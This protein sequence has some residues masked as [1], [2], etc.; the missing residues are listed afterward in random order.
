MTR[1][2]KTLKFPGTRPSFERKS[3]VAEIAVKGCR[4]SA[5]VSSHISTRDTGHLNCSHRYYEGFKCVSS[6]V[7]SSLLAAVKLKP[8]IL[9]RGKLIVNGIIIMET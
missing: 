8:E 7:L 4:P 2:K 9:P 5:H 6:L 1:Q 3:L